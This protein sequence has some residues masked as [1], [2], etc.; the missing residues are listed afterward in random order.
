V[1]YEAALRISQQRGRL[2]PCLTA[3]SARRAAVG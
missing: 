3:L 1:R 2:G